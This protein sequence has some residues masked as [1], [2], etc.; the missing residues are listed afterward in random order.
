MI[1]TID[2]D[3]NEI[4]F[5]EERN[6]EIIAKLQ[7][8]LEEF[9]K[10]KTDM[11]L[12]KKPI[13]LG[14]RFTKQMYSVLSSY[15]QM[16]VESV[17]KLDYDTIN[18][19]W[20]KY[21]ELTAYYN[22]YFEIVDNKQLL[23]CYMGINNRIYNKLEK[24]EDEE[25]RNL[26]AAINDSFI[27]LGFSASESGNAP[28]LAVKNRLGIKGAGHDLVSATDDLI[29]DKMSGIPTDRELANKVKELTGTEIKL[30]GEKK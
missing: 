8:V 25:I 30:L 27:G 11:M 19:F 5:L 22:R 18:N 17:A 9:Q 4:D 1:I 20:L 23:C 2:N 13:N 24:S 7:P 29:A 10:E 6:K 14:Y 16:S 3:G 28:A 15:G 21:L 12:L 26:M